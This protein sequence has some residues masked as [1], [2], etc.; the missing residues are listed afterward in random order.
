MGNLIL[1]FYKIQ[2]FLDRGIILVAILSDLE[3]NFDHVLGS[4]V[5]VGFMQDAAE[6]VVDGHGY[7]RIELLDVLANLSHQT[8]GNL[9]AVVS[10]LVQ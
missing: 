6:L 7:L 2:L 8:H 4:L 5:D 1:L 10:R 3:Q 9:N